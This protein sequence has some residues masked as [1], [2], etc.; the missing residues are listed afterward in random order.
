MSL[1]N[2]NSNDCDKYFNK[3]RHFT[4]L[5]SKSNSL[6]NFVDFPRGNSNFSIFGGKPEILKQKSKKKLKSSS[7]I[8][9]EPFVES[10]ELPFFSQTD[11]EDQPRTKNNKDENKIEGRK[12][13]TLKTKKNPIRKNPKK[14]NIFKSLANR[15]LKLNMGTGLLQFIDFKR[16]MAR[17][18]RKTH[19]YNKFNNILNYIVAQNFNFRSFLGWK[20]MWKDKNYGERIK[21]I[22]QKFFGETFVY[23]YI[24]FSKIKSEY[25]NLYYSKIE[26]FRKGSISPDTFGPYTYNHSSQEK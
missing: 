21:K 11:K 3:D 1:S 6:S 26:S 5:Y 12:K 7:S 14:K 2:S 8:K 13:N 20:S 19:Q 17:I 9:E 4:R 16:T 24:F 25:K 23:S 22:S 10:Q 18:Q 15:N